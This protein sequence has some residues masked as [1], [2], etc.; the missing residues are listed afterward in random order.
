MTTLPLFRL[1]QHGTKT[2]RITPASEP[3][4]YWVILY[5]GEEPIVQVSFREHDVAAGFAVEQL[6]RATGST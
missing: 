1:W 4:P 3:P 6:R 2:C 5:D